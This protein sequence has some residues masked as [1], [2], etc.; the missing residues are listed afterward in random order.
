MFLRKL[1]ATMD[2]AS[3]RAHSGAPPRLDAAAFAAR[4]A[5]GFQALNCIFAWHVA[6]VLGARGLWEATLSFEDLMH[7]SGRSACV[8]RLLECLGWLHLV[9]ASARG[10]LG[11]AE[12]D[13]A[14]EQDAHA[15]GGL[16]GGDSAGGGAS[17]QSA[18]HGAAAAPSATYQLGVRTGHLSPR[19]NAVLT[20]L[21]A[22]HTHLFE[23]GYD[24]NC[25]SDRRLV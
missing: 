18:A 16:Q 8:R 10:R 23:A 14:F 20:E 21:L 12:A 19:A 2:D 15:H 17:W 22:L 11:T 9:P 13:A 24:L 3:D 4:G 5:L 25:G 6:S 7:T 1:A